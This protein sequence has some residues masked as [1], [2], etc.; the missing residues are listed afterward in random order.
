MTVLLIKQFGVLQLIIKAWV[1][2]NGVDIDCIC[3]ADRKIEC[4]P[5]YGCERYV[6]KF[7]PIM[8]IED[9]IAAFNRTAKKLGVVTNKFTKEIDKL[10]KKIRS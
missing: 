5:E 10:N 8:A 2:F 4:G 1:K 7:I 6:V 9:D 3:S